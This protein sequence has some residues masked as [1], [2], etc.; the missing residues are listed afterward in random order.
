MHALG[1]YHEHQRPDRDDFI[2]I[3]D[4]WGSMMETDVWPKIDKYW[5]DKTAS[6]ATRYDIKSIMHYDGF[7]NGLWDDWTGPAITDLQGNP[8][9]KNTKLSKLDIEGL[10]TMYPCD[11]QGLFI[12]S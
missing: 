6:F 10:N 11:N 1:F 9:P 4:K 8:V 12:F 5:D 7:M 3:A 2:K